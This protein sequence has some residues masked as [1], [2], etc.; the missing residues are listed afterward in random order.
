MKFKVVLVALALVAI[1]GG[2]SAQNGPKAGC[3]ANSNKTCY[4]DKNNNGVCDTAEAKKC[5]AGKGQK[6]GKRGNGAGCNG[7]QGKACGGAFVDSNNNG[8]CDRVEK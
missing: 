8:V 7:G 6:Q 1:V 2:V 5:P 4:V 3:C